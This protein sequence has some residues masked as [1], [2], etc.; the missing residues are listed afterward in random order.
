M[1]HRYHGVMLSALAAGALFSG[2]AFA[3][4]TGGTI[5]YGPGALA[6]PTLSELG[7]LIT[8]LLVAVI[9]F[10]V[11]R[12]HPGSR[13]LASLLLLGGLTLSVASMGT[14]VVDVAHASILLV[15]DAA[16]G[17]TVVLP[18]SDGTDLPVQNNTAAPQRILNRNPGTCNAFVVPSSSPECT[19]GS[20][21]DP[22]GTCYV[23]FDSCDNEA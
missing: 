9:G 13:P 21:V 14:R 12:A 8:G 1:R 18:S 15:M 10:R 17:G 6:V 11:M 2:Q 22:G 5:T 16:G 3:G 7:L 20:T 4:T 19:I 23:R